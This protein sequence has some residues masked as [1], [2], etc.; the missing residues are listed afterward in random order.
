MINGGGRNRITFAPLYR[1][2]TLL[3][4]WWGANSWNGLCKSFVIKIHA[5]GLIAFLL[6][7]RLGKG[8]F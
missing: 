5:E 8:K 2:I 4:D 3:A 6:R 7:V 1:K